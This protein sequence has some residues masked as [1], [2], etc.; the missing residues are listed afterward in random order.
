MQR[1]VKM[2]TCLAGVDTVIHPGDLLT[3]DAEVA[4]AWVAEGMAIYVD[5]S[6]GI[7]TATAPPVE[8]AVLPAPRRRRAVK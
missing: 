7:E 1:T 5:E 6:T 8:T 3:L 2:T 4:Q